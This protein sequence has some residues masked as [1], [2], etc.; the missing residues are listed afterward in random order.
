[1]RLLLLLLLLAGSAAAQPGDPLKSP[2]CGEAREALDQARAA[3]EKD[4]GLAS[5]VEPLRKRAARI[6]LGVTDD[7]Q[8]SGRLAQP[9]QRVP[10]PIIAPSQRPPAFASPGLPPPLAIERP[11]VITS[12]DP[13][14]CWDS[15]GTRLNRAGPNLIGPSGLCTVQGALLSCP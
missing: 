10:A 14:G 6:C 12:C 2:E 1:M 3:A 7:A 8:P 13:G 4:P 9:P 11:P 15:N 5:Q